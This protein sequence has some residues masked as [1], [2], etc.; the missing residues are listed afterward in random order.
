MNNLKNVRGTRVGK[1]L[2]VT[3]KIKS[4]NERMREESLNYTHALNGRVSGAAERSLPT[5]ELMDN[6]ATN[7]EEERVQL[8]AG[9]TKHGRKKSAEET[10]LEQYRNLMSY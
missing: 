5:I 6:V 3:G 2:V 4:L 9:F 7:R 8:P 10:I 1:A